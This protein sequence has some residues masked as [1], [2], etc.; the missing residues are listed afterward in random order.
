MPCGPSIAGMK[1]RSD[2]A[3]VD[4]FSYSQATAMLQGWANMA[5]MFS[6]PMRAAMV[7]A[8]EAIKPSDDTKL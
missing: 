8:D 5:V 7:V 1:L 2:D 4:P 6:A 3:I